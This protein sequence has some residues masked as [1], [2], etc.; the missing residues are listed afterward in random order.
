MVLLSGINITMCIL[1]SSSGIFQKMHVS[2]HRIPIEVRWIAL[3][4]IDQVNSFV[5]LYSVPITTCYFGDSSMLK[6]LVK[7]PLFVSLFFSSIV[8]LQGCSLPVRQKDFRAYA[9]DSSTWKMVEH[10][11][12]E[13]C[14]PIVDFLTSEDLAI[15]LEFDN[16]DRTQH[17][18]GIRTSF[19]PISA[20]YEF[21]PSTITVKLKNGEVLKPRAF[22]CAYTIWDLNYL[23]TTQSLQGSL[24]VKLNTCYLLFFDHEQLSFTDDA[25]MSINDAITS[26]GVSLGIPLIH[27]RAN[28]DLKNKQESK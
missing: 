25:D 5:L 24:P 3:T 28:P 14:E 10:C 1:V 26:N 11:G 18:F 27:F 9:D 22:T 17:F 20:Q 15:R 8:L 2:G 6:Q 23:R 19:V 12:Y 4:T 7:Y 16:D 21:N 13:N